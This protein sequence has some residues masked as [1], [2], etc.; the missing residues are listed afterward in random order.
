MWDMVLKELASR[1]VSRLSK[2]KAV[3]GL[4]FNVGKRESNLDVALLK[5][6]CAPQPGLLAAAFR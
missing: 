2:A 5:P 1:K 4:D 6:L 3:T